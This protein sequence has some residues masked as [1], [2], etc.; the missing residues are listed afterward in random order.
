MASTMAVGRPS[1]RLGQAK[2]GFGPVSWLASRP[3]EA[4]VT[5]SGE[6]G[7]GTTPAR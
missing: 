3:P 5:I 1:Y 7:G 4:N 6:T 2:T